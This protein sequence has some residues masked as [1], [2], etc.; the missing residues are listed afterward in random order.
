MNPITELPQA[1]QYAIAA[2]LG[3]LMLAW[4][5]WASHSGR[6]CEYQP[7]TLPAGPSLP[8]P[9]HGEVLPARRVRA[10]QAPFLPGPDA[11]AILPP[12]PLAHHAAIARM[13]RGVAVLDFRQCGRCSAN[14]Y[15]RHSRAFAIYQ[16]E[17]AAQWHE[18]EESLGAV[19]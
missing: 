19:E 11:A 2:I 1:V 8:T 6:G 15:S 7:D 9:E 3:I 12:L 10:G 16:V 5:V 14:P 17:Y 13:A 4:G 18:L